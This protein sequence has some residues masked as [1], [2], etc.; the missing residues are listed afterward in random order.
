EIVRWATPVTAFQRTATCDTEL[1]GKQIRKGD[2]VAMF[3][4]SGNRDETVFDDPNSF[5]ITRDPNDHLGFGGTG[6]HFCIGTP[7]ARLEI[8]L[9]FS[10]IADVMPDIRKLGEPERLQSPWL[11]GIKH[12]ETDFTGKCPVAH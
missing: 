6:A 2:R 8:E 10:A 3:Y 4:V 1:G 7:L 9:I 12:L 5:D 11:N